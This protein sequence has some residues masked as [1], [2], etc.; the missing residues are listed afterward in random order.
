[1]NLMP[2]RFAALIFL[3]FF[4]EGLFAQCELPQATQMAPFYQDMKQAFDYLEAQLNT[5]Q[6]FQK[7]L[8]IPGKRVGQF[9][10]ESSKAEINGHAKLKILESK[11]NRDYEF[12]LPVGYI[13]ERIFAEY[14]KEKIIFAFS[15]TDQNLKEIRV[16]SV[17][18]QTS[19]G[20]KIGSTYDTVKKL[21]PNGK[22]KRHLKT[23]FYINSGITFV[24]KKDIVS[25]IVIF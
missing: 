7:N 12:L 6:A 21:F 4:S 8:I 16:Q 23:L 9:Y 22:E 14:A 2:G 1:M 13:P 10:L 19:K 5:L 20:L 25:E 17:E 11:V 24:I 18:Y 3:V 15:T